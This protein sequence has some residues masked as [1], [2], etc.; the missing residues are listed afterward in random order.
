[1]PAGVYPRPSGSTIAERL[2]YFSMPEPNSGCLLWIGGSFH[3][4]G[5]GQLKVDGKPTSTHILQWERHHGPV[6]R[7]MQVL[8]KCDVPCCIEIKHLWLGTMADN[9]RDKV[10]KGRQTRGA[11]HA[12]AKLTDDA[13]R[14]IR[15]DQRS[16]YAIA[17]SF[18]V[19]QSL[20]WQIKRGLIWGHLP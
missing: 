13:V 2:E 10:A 5:Y 11:K 1:M 15:S 19:S 3:T 12:N 18:C 16:T 17:D 7:G 6:P 4:F 9:Q 14:L 8:H 20:V